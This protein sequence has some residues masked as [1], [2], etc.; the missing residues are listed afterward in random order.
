M[1]ARFSVPQP[2]RPRDVSNRPHMQSPHSLPTSDADPSRSDTPVPGQMFARSPPIFPPGPRIPPR[3]TSRQQEFDP[4]M[5]LPARQH[6]R[7]FVSPTPVAYG[8]GQHSLAPPQNFMRP[9]SWGPP[10]TS[11]TLDMVSGIIS[12]RPATAR[13]PVLRRS[14][15][16]QQLDQENS[17]QAIRAA[18]MEERAAVSMRYDGADAGGGRAEVMN[19]TPPRIGRFERHMG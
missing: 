18:L 12:Q 7:H 15:P 4:P 9:P 14:V 17:D 10:S 11:T 2:A 19:E 16:R 5:R 6:T 13:T 3:N 1:P 8:V